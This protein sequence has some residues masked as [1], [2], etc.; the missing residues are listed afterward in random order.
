[1]FVWFVVVRFVW[2][3]AVAPDRKVCEALDELNDRY[4]FKRH[5]KLANLTNDR[6]ACSCICVCLF[7][8]VALVRLFDVP[9]L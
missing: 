2:F 7:A 9:F 8:L 5:R 4:E 6:T 1:M 3:V